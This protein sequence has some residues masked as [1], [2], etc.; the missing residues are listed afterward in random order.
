[1]EKRDAAEAAGFCH[2]DSDSRD[3][4]YILLEIP[5]FPNMPNVSGQIL[6]VECFCSGQRKGLVLFHL[7]PLNWSL[8]PRIQDLKY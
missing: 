3:L 6:G 8:T 1:M 5:K 2:S 7:E 4:F